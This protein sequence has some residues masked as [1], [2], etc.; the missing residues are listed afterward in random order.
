M[1]KSLIEGFE[2]ELEN[3]AHHN[4]MNPCDYEVICPGAF[5]MKELDVS[6]CNVYNCRKCWE[7]AINDFKSSN[8]LI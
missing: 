1:L 3:I 4:Y 7:Q 6:E 5:G 2:N 8:N